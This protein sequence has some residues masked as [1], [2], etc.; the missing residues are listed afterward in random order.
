MG[1]VV[2]KSKLGYVYTWGDNCFRQVTN[3]TLNFLDTPWM[4]ETEE[5]KIRALQAVAGLRA[6]FILTEN[7]KLV[8]FGASSSFECQKSVFNYPL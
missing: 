2:A 3:Q 1:H 4:M 5:G 6:T 8:G 7:L